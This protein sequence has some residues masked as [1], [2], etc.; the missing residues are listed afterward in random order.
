MYATAAAQGN[1]RHRSSWQEGLGAIVPT[2]NFQLSENCFS[3]N[4][5]LGL[6][7]SHFGVI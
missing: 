3:E 6:T 5:I 7:I 1:T 2:L 4:L